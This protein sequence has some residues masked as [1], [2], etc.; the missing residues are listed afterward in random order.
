MPQFFLLL[1]FLFLETSAYA[2]KKNDS[3]LLQFNFTLRER[4]ELW[5]GI[6]AKNYGNPQ[7]YGS[8]NDKILFQRVVTGFT[9]NFNAKFV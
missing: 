4:F 7:G 8:L 3:T 6:N 2:V 1:I 9:P 5:N